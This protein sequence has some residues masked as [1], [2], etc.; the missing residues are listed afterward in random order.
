MSRRD[1]VLA[2]LRDAPGFISAQSLYAE[3]RSRGVRI[4]LATVYRALQSMATSGEADQLRSDDGEAL[5]R[6]CRSDSHHHH[7]LCRDCG[8]AVEIDDEVVEEWAR[9]V[10]AE[11]GFVAVD[12]TVEITGTCST[13]A[14]AALLRR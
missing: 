13:C 7:L 9:S 11:H 3:L 8:R 14:A 4:G 6:L 12:H 2:G 10:A 5:Y 1:D